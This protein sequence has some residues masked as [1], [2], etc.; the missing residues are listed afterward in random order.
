MATMSAN[1]GALAPHPA[2]ATSEQRRRWLIL[3][4]LGF[5][6]VASSRLP[7]V[8]GLRALAALWVVAFHIEA[9]SH[10]RFAHIP[11]LNLFLQSGSTGVS[12]FLVLSG[13]CLYV[14]FAGGRTDRFKTT[15]FLK[16]RCRRLMPAYYTSLAFV[17]ILNL[18]GGLWLGF[19]A[20][21][22]GMAVWEAVTHGALI[23]TLFPN[24]FYALNGA[25]WSLGLEWQ[26]YL[27]LPILI[28]GIRKFGI[29]PTVLAVVTC[30]I[31]Y[32]LIMGL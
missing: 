19:H 28:L 25:Y 26:L 13:F 32:G 27:T 30:N 22:P 3:R 10:A 31:V 9:F 1:S 11:G 8:D 15:D 6:E 5:P 29:K 20:L 16:R 18:G 23:H 21:S 4:R 7:G 14:P 2:E 12:L 17:L 24:T